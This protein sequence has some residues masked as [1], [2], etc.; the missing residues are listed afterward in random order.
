[1]QTSLSRVFAINFFVVTMSVELKLSRSSRIYHSNEPLEGKLIAK[2]PSSISHHGVRLTATGT[3]NLQVR[4]GTAGVIESIYGVVKPLCIM[5]KSIEIRSSGKLGS[6]IT[7]IPFSIDLREQGRVGYERFYET[8]HGEN[9]SIQYLITADIMRG[10]L[11]KSLAATVEFIIESEK[12]YLSELPVSPEMVSF[13]I[14]QDTQRHPLLPKLV[15]GGFRVT[16][17]IP[18]QCS[19]LDSLDGELTV[20]A[21]AL[22]LRS[23]DV[24]ILRIESIL[25]GEKIV[26]ETS[27]VQT[28]Q[29]ADG[30]V[31]HGMTLPIY[32]ILPRL[33][34]CPTVKAG[35]REDGEWGQ[36]RVSNI[37]YSAT[38]NQV[39]KNENLENIKAE[40][41]T[42]KGGATQV[43]VDLDVQKQ[44][45]GFN[46]AKN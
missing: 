23:I 35:S 36:G 18:T 12:A 37:R 31:C 20:E 21:S 33:L 19:L 6:G 30:D 7:E 39:Y 26:K 25:V 15:T 34:T 32:V 4:G 42:H 13:Y 14:T 11:H 29:I 43:T 28:T 38:P 3:V 16:G 44:T 8:F 27:V 22:P 46:A 40:L 9:I 1:S 41:A 2:F 10:Y 17:K 5:K 45:M 24:H